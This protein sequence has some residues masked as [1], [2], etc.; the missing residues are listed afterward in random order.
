MRVSKKRTIAV[1][2]P[3]ATGLR[4]LVRAADKLLSSYGLNMLL[5][6]A[7]TRHV[8]TQT[9]NHIY[10]IKLPCFVMMVP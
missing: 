6:Y 3:A 7:I 5:K 10:L 4:K 2:P 1:P 9:K 8:T